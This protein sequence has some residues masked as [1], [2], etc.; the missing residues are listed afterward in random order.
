[1]PMK[2]CTTTLD[3]GSFFAGLLELSYVEAQVGHPTHIEENVLADAYKTNK[4]LLANRASCHE[5]GSPRVQMC[6]GKMFLRAAVCTPSFG[7]GQVHGED[8][9]QLTR[10]GVAVKIVIGM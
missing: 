9:A 10:S 6:L 1:M 5:A 3:R 4:Y 7:C 8:F 2:V